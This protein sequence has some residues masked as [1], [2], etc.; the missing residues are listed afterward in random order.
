MGS[1]LEARTDEKSKPIKTAFKGSIAGLLGTGAAWGAALE[2]VYVIP[3]IFGGADP[4][5]LTD[6]LTSPLGIGV[7][8]IGFFLGAWSYFNDNKSC[9][10]DDGVVYE[11]LAGRERIRVDD[12]RRFSEST[13]KPH[14]DSIKRS[15]FYKRLA[16]NP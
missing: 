16:D 1:S 11:R 15:D 6:Y 8:S 4:A 10:Y 7:A 12:T 9:R 14:L 13:L 3:A 2:G 5:T